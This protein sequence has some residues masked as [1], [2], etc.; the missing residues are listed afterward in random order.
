MRHACL[1]L[2]SLL[3]VLTAE[4][5]RAQQLSDLGP[6][7]QIETGQHEGTVNALAELPSEAAFISV[8]DDKTARLWSNE[9]LAPQ[10][11][12]HPPLGARD[13]GK[14]YA[15]A[16]GNNMVAVAGA[17]PDGHGLYAVE[18]YQLPSMRHFATI[19]GLLVVRALSFSPDG[20][21]LAI[22]LEGGA[23][24]IVFDLQ[25]HTIALADRHSGHDMASPS[26]KYPDSGYSGDVTGMDFSRTDELAVAADGK[27][28]L[29]RAMDMNA[30]PV[31]SPA[32]GARSARFSPDGSRIAAGD[33]TRPEVHVLDGATLRQVA[34]LHGAPGDFGALGTVAWSPDGSVLYAAGT[35]KDRADN[36]LVRRFLLRGN[37]AVDTVAAGNTIMDLLANG[38]DVIFAS[39]DPSIGR[40]DQAGHMVAIQ[41]SHHIDFRNAGLTSFAISQD[42]AVV[43]FPGG[44][45][46]PPFVFDIFQRT[47]A[48]AATDTFPLIAPQDRGPGL[49]VTDWRN[50]RTPRLNGRPIRLSAGDNEVVRSVAVSPTGSGVA[51]G[52][53]YY[54]RFVTPAGEAWNVVTPAD[55]WAVAVSG[56]GRLVAAAMADGSVHW[57]DA[58]HGTE[59]LGLF[60]DPF[61][62][63][64]MPRWVLWT[65]QGFFDHDHRDDGL[66]DGRN[67]IGYVMDAT[68]W[69]TTQFVQ[70]GQMYSSF[71]RPDLVGLQFRNQPNDAVIIG[72]QVENS[73]SVSNV[74]SRGMPSQVTLLDVCGHDP[75]DMSTGCPDTRPTDTKNP[76]DHPGASLATT[77]D[78]VIVQYKLDARQGGLGS[79]VIRRDGAVIRPDIFPDAQT[80]T[81]RTEEA[82]IPLGAGL[83]TIEVAPVSVDGKIQATGS[84]V[85][86]VTVFHTG[87]MAETARSTGPAAPSG[88]TPAAP[89]AAP[90]PTLYMLSV[91]VS[92]YDQ[93]DL[94]LQNAANDAN[95]MAALMN[96]PD[97]PVY[98]K[99]VVKILTNTQATKDNIVAALKEI[100]KDA[101]PD[102]LVVIFFAGHGQEVNGK[103][104][105][106][107]VDMGTHDPALFQRAMQTGN[108][109][110]EH[111]VDTLFVKEGLG[112]DEMLPLVQSIKA[113]HVAILLDTCYSASLAT[114]DAV[115]RRDIN[116]TVTNQIGTSVG[117]FVLSSSINLALDSSGTGQT[118][119]PTDDQGHGLFTSFLL[120][121]LQGK[122]DFRHNQQ[123]DIYDLATYTQSQVEQATAKMPQPQQPMFFLNGNDFFA[124]RH[125]ASP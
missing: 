121:A 58:A 16:A 115:L 77:A 96:T 13:D 67:L 92:N 41:R 87:T 8:S 104:Y 32:I 66:P 45:G 61:A 123:I 4:R 31:I 102:D 44:E 80:K 90:L 27:I 25:A 46:R 116:T 85:A 30:R 100:A 106:A 124:V 63:D 125:T 7:L 14:L 101:Q 83:N 74:I 57:Y 107:P 11:L 93:H 88:T 97:A 59:S 47:I 51:V 6:Y 53:N 18:V 113:A 62:R 108:T 110:T 33:L 68:N 72:Q 122:A 43:R 71:F 55:V 12:L 23:G 3:C 105:Y 69:Q 10:G 54:L 50:S 24:I 118:Q 48:L 98:S 19:P 9:T 99:P 52:T 56:D 15:V 38:S 76:Q 79:V 64:V 1:V 109:T 112:E 28:R 49:V 84:D 78:A 22:G 95:A 103:Y 21:Y 70:I 89:A 34:L 75:S 26:V 35:Y 111:A 117:R 86:Q 2:F 65:P 39:A 94:D 40:I 37:V 29:Y 5:A 17:V 120:Q 82:T 73:G 42:G 60:V 119:Q 91:G 114:Q 20:R 81:S 36:Y